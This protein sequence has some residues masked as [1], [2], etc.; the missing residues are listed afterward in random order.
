MKW[1][2]RGMLEKSKQL[3]GYLKQEEEAYKAWEK[4]YGEVRSVPC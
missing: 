3:E 4:T 1:Q 2:G